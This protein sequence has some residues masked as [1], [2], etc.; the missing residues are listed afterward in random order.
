MSSTRDAP[1][2][3]WL[4]FGCIL[5]DADMKIVKADNWYDQLLLYKSIS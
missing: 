2:A 5:V 4:H 3:F 1:V